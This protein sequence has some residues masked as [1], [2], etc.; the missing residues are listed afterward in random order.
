MFLGWIKLIVFHRTSTT[1]VTKVTPIMNSSVKYRT[2]WLYY[3]V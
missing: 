2:Y 3:V 1:Q